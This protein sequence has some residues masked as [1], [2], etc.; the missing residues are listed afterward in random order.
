MLAAVAQNIFVVKGA[1]DDPSSLRAHSPTAEAAQRPVQES[2][3]NLAVVNQRQAEQASQE[4]TRQ[5]EQV[6]EQQRSALSH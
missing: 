5:R 4:Q 3:D 6:Q 2:L 1:L